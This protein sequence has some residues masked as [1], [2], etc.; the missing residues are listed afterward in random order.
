MSTKDDKYYQPREKVRFLNKRTDK[1]GWIETFY[2]AY[3]SIH[4]KQSGQVPFLRLD[5]SVL[6]H[7]SRVSLKA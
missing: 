2:V 5:A 3:L 7:K 4:A 1:A 6:C